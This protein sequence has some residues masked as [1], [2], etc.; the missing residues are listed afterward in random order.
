[1]EKC[2]EKIPHDVLWHACVK[3]NFSL[4]RI[5]LLLMVYGGKRWVK[6]REIV[7]DT[8]Q[9]TRSIVAGC[10]FATTLLR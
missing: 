4:R 6:V 5:R 3:H 8:I 1:M 10:S 9:I 7:S 2:Y